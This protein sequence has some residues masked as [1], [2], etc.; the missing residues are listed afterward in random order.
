MV[1][2][3]QKKTDEKSKVALD[4]LHQ[5]QIDKYEE[6]WES[7]KNGEFD[8]FEDVCL[9]GHARHQHRGDEGSCEVSSCHCRNFDNSI[10]CNDEDY[11]EPEE[12][13]IPREVNLGDSPG[14][15]KIYE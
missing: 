14:G 6:D 13:D 8:H 4:K 5:Q 2:I 11:L 15:F 12:F 7:F 1:M 3:F 10:D 9:C